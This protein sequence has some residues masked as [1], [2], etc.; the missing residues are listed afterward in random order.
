MISA[1]RRKELYEEL[2]RMQEASDAFYKHAVSLKC[3]AW[4]EMAGVMNEFIKVNR[5]AVAAGIDI[6]FANKHTGVIPPMQTFEARYLGEKIGCMF[7]A[8]RDD[9]LMRI[10]VE[11]VQCKD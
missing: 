5:N 1:K 11:E 10:F 9:K 2:D 8:L 6:D 4:I 7:P 3:H